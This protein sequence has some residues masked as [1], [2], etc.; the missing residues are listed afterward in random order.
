[1]AGLEDMIPPW[2]A[3]GLGECLQWGHPDNGKGR[4][5]EASR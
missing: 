4:Q 1:M 2:P 3:L 5:R